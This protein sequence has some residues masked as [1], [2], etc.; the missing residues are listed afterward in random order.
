MLFPLTDNDT[1]VTSVPVER[2]LATIINIGRPW[3]FT[4]PTFQ[5]PFLKLPLDTFAY[6]SL[7]F[8]DRAGIFLTLTL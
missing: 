7:T 3:Y 2:S 1:C 4:V 5:T 6:K 8:T